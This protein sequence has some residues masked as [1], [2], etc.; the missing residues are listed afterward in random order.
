MS[1]IKKVT[2]ILTLLASVGIAWTIITLKNIPETFDW[3]NDSDS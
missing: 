3:E 1:K 2:F